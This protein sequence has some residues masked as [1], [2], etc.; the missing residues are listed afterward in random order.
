M[1]FTNTQKVLDD[2]GKYLVEEYKDALILNNVNASDNLYNSVR[3]I[4]ETNDKSISV[5]L[6]LADYYIYVENG[7]R[8]GKMPPIDKIERWIEVKPV[9]PTPSNN[10]RIP[11]VRQLAYLISRKIGLEGIKPKP[12]LQQSITNVW[13]VF[14]EY[15][16][17]AITKD[18]ENNINEIIIT[19]TK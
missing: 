13:D 4:L 10:G 15:I 7:R 12:L 2:F 1:Q 11:T 6:N 18:V 3:Y 14:E 9:L 16:S 17:E 8:A 5:S 19:L